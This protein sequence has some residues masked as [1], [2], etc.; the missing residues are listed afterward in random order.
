MSEDI[1]TIFVVGFPDDMKEREFQNMF[2]F[3]PGFE[4]ATLKI[5]SGEDAF[6]KDSQKKQI[7]GFAKF[8]TRLEA[9]EA[10]D[11]LT[12]RKVDAEKNCMLKAEMAKKNL[13]TR[14]GLSS[15]GL[16]T[17]VA[18]TFGLDTPSTALG[19]QQQ[20]QQQQSQSQQQQQQQ[21]PQQNVPRTASLTGSMLSSAARPEH[22]RISATRAFNPFNDIPLAS[23]PIL[24]ANAHRSFSS[25]QFSSAFSS[26]VEAQAA[27][28]VSQMPGTAGVMG[29]FMYG[30]QPGSNLTTTGPQ[31]SASG[32]MMNRRGSVHGSTPVSSSLALSAA[33][34]ATINGMQQQDSSEHGSTDGDALQIINQ[35]QQQSSSPKMQ[36]QQSR[37]GQ[38]QVSQMPQQPPKGF[39]G[40]RLAV[41]DIA[42]L[43]PRINQLNLGQMSANSMISP[44]GVPY[45]ASVTTPVGMV[46]PMATTRS[47]NSNDQNPPCNTLYVGNL[48]VGAKEDELRQIFQNALGFRRMSY[49]AKPNSGPMCFVE[50][51]SIDFA[52]LAMGDL[53]GRMLSN[54]VGGG[55]RLSYS[56]NPLGVRSQNN[57]GSAAAVS[58]MPPVTPVLNSAAAAAAVAAAAAASAN[59][60]QINGSP[61]GYSVAAMQ[62]QQNYGRHHQYDTTSSPPSSVLLSRANTNLAPPSQ[63]HHQA[64]VG[65]HRHSM[66]SSSAASPLPSPGTAKSG[67]QTAVPKDALSFLHQPIHQ[68][69]KQASADH[70]LSSTGSTTPP[71]T[72]TSS[73]NH[74]ANIALDQ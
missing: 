5:P 14:R 41:L 51:E 31:M 52:T 38:S 66:S 34:G 45:S 6:D 28:A 59:G 43:Q 25:S 73:A 58:G 2:T 42:A 4:A 63:Q 70:P 61:Y 32:M 56:K 12:G 22:L 40:Q 3:S 60:Y 64:A 18:A 7:I 9:L 35:K 37:E 10:R 57:S 15:L 23:A 53:D 29:S 20:Q 1:T 27:P 33:A 19:F 68:L 72:T 55:I 74:I 67:D 65:N 13:H 47:V 16:S 21:T 17:A 71:Q 24:G 36:A 54:S 48:P 30:D 44:M 11:I 46:L 39:S 26:N 49:K 69:H 8:H 62:Q 50:F